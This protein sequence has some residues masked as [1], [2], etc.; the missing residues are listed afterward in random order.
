MGKEHTLPLTK[1]DS[2]WII[3]Y[4]AQFFSKIIIESFDIVLILMNY[5]D[6]IRLGCKF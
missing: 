6:A 1:S 5:D 2:L 3:S 4:F